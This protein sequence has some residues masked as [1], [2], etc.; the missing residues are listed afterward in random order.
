MPIANDVYNYIERNYVPNSPIFLSELIIPGIAAV[1]VRQQL[2]KLTEDG[3]LRRF[4]TGIY[5]I[6]LKTMF[7]SGSSLSIDE[8]IRKKYLL[9]GGNVCGY[10]G[11]L[12]FANLLGLTT[13][14]PSQYEVYTNKATTEYRDVKL[15]SY[16]IILRKPCCQV[17]EGNVAIL[18]FL[19]L[20]R[21]LENVSEV[22]G[23]ELATK[24][25]NYM[26]KKN[27]TFKS[28]RPYLKFYPDSIYKNMYE[29]RLLNGIS[30]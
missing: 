10:V 12:M 28:L 9:D 13:Q 26:D 1:T 19:D 29:A 21:N 17:D 22:E 20:F 7:L 3:R 4:D 16:R 8:V 18:Q 15:Q 2:K 25:I 5:Y 27:I 14:V 23:E 11:G 30:S 24:I 6:P